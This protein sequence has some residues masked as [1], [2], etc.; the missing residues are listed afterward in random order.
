MPGWAR[1]LAVSLPTAARLVPSLG[2]PPERRL[3]LSADFKRLYAT[4]RRLGN[5][6]FTAVVH[7]N[8]AGAPRLGMSVAARM[9]R[10]AVERNRVR[11]LVRESFRIHQLRLPAVDIIVGIRS[12]VREASSLQLR[13]SL[14]RLWRK[15]S[16]TC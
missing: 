8:A 3:R 15:I 9:L 13:D 1:H 7:P 4:G 12:S 5:E 10:R 11:R 6:S 14:E 16:A 2:L